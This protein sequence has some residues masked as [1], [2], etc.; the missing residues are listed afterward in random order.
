MVA[1]VARV[2]ADGRAALPD[3]LERVAELLAAAVGDACVIRLLSEDGAW[4]RTAAA[5]HRDPDATAA[6]R[7]AFMAAPQPAAAGAAATVLATGEPLLLPEVAP[8]R[9]RA[10]ADPAQRAYLDRYPTHSLLHHAPGRPR[11]GGRHAPPGARPVAGA[12]R[13]RRRAAGARRRRARGA[14]DRQRPVGRGRRGRRAPA[15]GVRLDR[16]ARAADAADDDQ[17]LRPAPRAR[18]GSARAGPGAPGGGGG[19]AS[20]PGRPAGGAGG[21]PVGRGAHPPGP[22]G[23]APRADRPGGVGA[24]G[25]GARGGGREAARAAGWRS[26][27]RGR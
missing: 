3:R 14:G 22:P 18:G 20:G 11:A 26:T 21:R 27:R 25:A 5:R 4:L 12:V 23:A 15:R 24:A 9:L 17:G 1:E 7:A 2:A 8:D 6:L 13:C 10:L 16:V 19:Q